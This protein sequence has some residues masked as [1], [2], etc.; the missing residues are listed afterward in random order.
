[1][2]LPGISDGE[3][4]S[5]LTELE[6]LAR[7]LG[8]DPIARITQRRA[9]LAPGVV[10]GAGKLVELAGWT[11]GSGVVE[12]YSKPGGKKNAFEEDEDDA[13]VEPDEPDENDGE[14]ARPS[15]AR[16]RGRRRSRSPST[17]QPA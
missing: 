4:E 3:L 11:G 6:R 8:L 2:Q 12:A 1:V 16:R 14:G 9:K 10:L 13:E 5:S 17:Q 15:R 7:T